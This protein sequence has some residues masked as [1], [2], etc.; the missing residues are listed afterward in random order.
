VTTT[1]IPTLTTVDDAHT[2]LRH[3]ADTHDWV[4]VFWD[5]GWGDSDQAVEITIIVDG[6]GQQPKAWIT[7]DVYRGLRDQNI[8]GENRLM[9]FKARR[10]HDFKTPPAK[11]PAGPNTT[12]IAEQAIRRFM[13][14]HPDLPVAA[15][16]YRG[17]SRNT[18]GY[19]QVNKEYAETPAAADGW[20]VLI[21]PGHSDM[22]VSAQ[23]P[24]FFGYNIIGDGV[25]DRVRYPRTGDNE[26]DVDALAGHVFQRQL[27]DVVGVLVDVIAAERAA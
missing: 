3:L 11:E 7:P 6:N 20:H 23:K 17:L 10:V 2:L 22:A 16:F 19:P 15:E 12:E 9:T 1:D 25:A 21:L 26:V 27:A 18:H 8:I 13:D 24:S 4:S 5:R 14:E